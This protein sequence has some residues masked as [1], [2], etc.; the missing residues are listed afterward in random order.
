MKTK[1]IPKM[2]PA[3][4]L[5][6]LTIVFA[7]T[8]KVSASYESAGMESNLNLGENNTL[9]F[10]NNQ[11]PRGRYGDTP[12]DSIQC[13]RNL[14]LYQ[15][16]YNQR[17]FQLAFEPWRE[18]FWGCPQSSQNLFIRG[19]ILIKMKY[20]EETDP[21]R[22]EAWV[23]T[24]MMVYD[25]RIKYWGHSPTSREGLVLGRK[26]VDLFTLR[27]NDVLEVYE[28]SKKSIEIEGNNSQADVILVNMQMLV[29]LVEAGLEPVENILEKY[30]MLMNII[31]HNLEHNPSD[32]RLFSQA[33]VQVDAMFEPYA[34]CDNIITLFQPRFDKE[35]ENIELLEKI[36]TLLNNSGCTEEDLFLSTT[37]NLH[38]LQPNAQSA[39]LMGRLES[40]RQNYREAVGYFEEAVS[41][42][43]TENE[44]FTALMLLADITYRNLRQ[45]SQARNYA[46][47]ASSIDPENGRPFI[48]IGEIY[49]ASASACGDNDLTKSVAY[50]AAVD[51]FIQARNV[52]NDPVVQERATQL[53]NSYSQYF[54]NMEIIFFYG[55]SEGDT[56]RVECWIN[57]TTRVRPRR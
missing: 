26:A 48:L 32:E 54:P 9:A 17:N 40:N 42:Y 28:I 35:P 14:S 12:E 56:Y 5:L 10:S 6:I 31:E 38:R 1:Q 24:L 16:Y 23:D 55:L 52:D 15:E 18:A 44:K 25:N 45:F 36:T 34:T 50:W 27:P 22:R 47:Q 20:N 49:A 43:E 4:I 46:L 8:G 7:H 30:D 21:L 41:L 11:P 51:K 33:K 53:I 29:R 3:A 57:E 2:L 19:I 39:F 37:R 13:I